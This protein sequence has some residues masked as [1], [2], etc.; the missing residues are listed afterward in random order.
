MKRFYNSILFLLTAIFFLQP[1]ALFAYSCNPIP[2]PC[3]LYWKSDYVFIGTVREIIKAQNGYEYEP[4]FDVDRPFRGVTT[5]TF[6]ASTNLIGYDEIKFQIGK[7]YV[8]YA[9]KHRDSIYIDSMCAR[10][11]LIEKSPLDVEFLNSLNDGKPEF[12]IWGTAFPGQYR[13]RINIKL[14]I[15]VSKGKQKI[16]ASSN[17]NGRFKVSVNEEGK[18]KV[19]I[20]LPRGNDFVI[21]GSEYVNKISGRGRVGNRRFLD[22][23]VEVKPDHCAFIVIPVVNKRDL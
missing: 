8:V 9:N 10:S 12:E 13:G 5:P 6:K 21:G 15:E 14:D 19:R 4:F 7:Q 2:P 11:G 22:Y 1:N 20:W 23:E 16:A 3:S 17:E 18:Y